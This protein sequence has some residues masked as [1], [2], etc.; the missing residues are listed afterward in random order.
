VRGKTILPQREEVQSC[1]RSEAAQARGYTTVLHGPEADY[2]EAALHQYL[3]LAVYDG[4]GLK[5]LFLPPLLT[6][7]IIFVVL[8][9]YCIYLDIK[10][11]KLMSTG[12]CYADRLSVPRRNS[13]R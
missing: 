5:G 9:P 3:R 13:T 6:A 12:G 2:V 4:L 8:F 7:F 1:A 11:T 10:R